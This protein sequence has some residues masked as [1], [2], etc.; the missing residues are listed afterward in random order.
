MI[1][2]IRNTVLS[3]ISKDNRGYITPEEFNQFARQAQL[4]LFEQYFYDYSNN[5]NKTNA[6][7]HN[8]GYSDITGRLSEVIDRF[9][10]TNTPLYDGASDKFYAPGDNPTTDPKPYQIIRLTYNGNK[11]IEKVSQQKLLNLL[12]SNLTAP[13][14]AYPVYT[15]NDYNSGSASIAVYPTTIVS[16]VDI[17]YIRH[18][19]DPKWTYTS[20]SG[21]QPVF[22]Q[23]A[24]DYQDFELPLSDGPSLV[25]KICAYSGVSIRE[26]DVVQL[27]NSEEVMDI[28]Q[29]N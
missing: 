24:S 16:N 3:I 11:E 12:S 26:S 10:I 2:Q 9:L 17:L 22:N 6:R 15:M 5:L 29:K 8:S 13:T 19:F 20:L 25:V 23:S 28:Q 4:E 7:L 21:G 27:M 18:P 14:T 1:N